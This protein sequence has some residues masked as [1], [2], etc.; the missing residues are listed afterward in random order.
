MLLIEGE[1][2]TTA[3]ESRSNFAKKAY[4]IFSSKSSAILAIG[5]LVTVIP[6]ALVLW[7]GNTLITF[8]NSD[9]S[10]SREE[11][12]SP[13]KW[14][15]AVL[16]PIAFAIHGYRKN[17]VNFSGAIFGVMVGFTLALGSYVFLINL[18]AFFYTG[19]QATKFRSELKRK[20]EENFKPGGSR[21]WVQVLC[22]CGP[23]ALLAIIYILDCGSGEIPVDFDSNYHASWLSMSI[24]GTFAAACGDTWSSEL[25]SVIRSAQPVLITNFK[26]VPRGTNGGVSAF[27]IWFGFIGGL[28]IG[29]THYATL[30]YT[31]DTTLLERAPSQWPI[32]IVGGFAGLIGSI[33]DSCIGATFQ[34]SGRH[35]ITGV[36]VEHPGKDVIHISGRDILDNHGVNLITNVLMALIT[37]KFANALFL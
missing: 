32:I 5:T 17:S 31:A 30:I 19:S 6:L 4:G 10:Y 22:N 26:P 18:I 24:L 36:I 16:V 33:I 35:K 3:L 2:T 21:N 27:G 15:I 13:T 37:P 20:L 28:L 8:V 25:G 9:N 34:Y 1:I 11:F 29:L 7:L 14:L 23:A 12:I